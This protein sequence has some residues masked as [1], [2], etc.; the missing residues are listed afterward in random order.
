MEEIAPVWY[1][2]AGDHV[3]LEGKEFEVLN[4]NLVPRATTSTPY[5]PNAATPAGGQ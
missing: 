1:I 3:R 2:L 5:T 4:K